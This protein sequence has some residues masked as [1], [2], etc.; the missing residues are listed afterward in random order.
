MQIYLFVRFVDEVTRPLK[1]THN[2]KVLSLY[3]TEGIQLINMTYRQGLQF[4]INDMIKTQ[5]IYHEI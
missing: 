1:L 2:F 4:F 5:I 3:P